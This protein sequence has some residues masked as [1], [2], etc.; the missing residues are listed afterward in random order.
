MKRHWFLF[1]IAF[2]IVFLISPSMG[3]GEKIGEEFCRPETKAPQVKLPAFHTPQAKDPSPCSQVSGHC[4]GGCF[5]IKI[6]NGK[7]CVSCPPGFKYILY[8]GEKMCVKCRGGYRYVEYNGVNM[9]VKCP[10]GYKYTRYKGRDM[11][12]KCDRGYTYI[13]D[14]SEG[15]CV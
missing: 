1:L 10:P 7:K 4:G 3:I 9:C 13:D 5:L 12:V 8:N 14:G 2:T 11:C 6:Q 15:L